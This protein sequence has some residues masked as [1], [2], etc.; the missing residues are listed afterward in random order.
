MPPASVRTLAH[1]RRA[2][3]LARDWATADRLKSEIEEAGWRVVDRGPDFALVPAIPA[4][5][6][7][8]GVLVHGAPER[9][10]SELAAP[11]SPGWT[12]VLIGAG[13][14]PVV[15]G[16][17]IVR[18]A[19]GSGPVPVDDAETLRLPAG[20]SPAA[21]IEAGLRRVRTEW[22]VLVPDLAGAPAPGRLLTALS[23]DAV[24]GD[25][26]VVAFGLAGATTAD[27]H[28]F[29]PVGAGDADVLLAGPL[30]VRREDLAAVLP[31][32][33]R[34][35]SPDRF[36]EW[37]SLALRRD[38]TPADDGSVRRT[39]VVDAGDA[40]G[41]AR[42]AA[43]ATDDRT[44]KRDFYRILDRFGLDPSLLSIDR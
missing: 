35:V 42:R 22:V 37:L 2:A 40:D 34:I 3:R 36:F 8:D 17:P 5:V 30:A 25:R 1:D 15:D 23:Q 43:E 41:I 28:A 32:D 16:V 7:I 18:V 39:V 44:A 38:A 14:A 29:E 12:L 11:A 19:A 20:S 13:P 6:T 10:P 21:L 4:D 33:R 31:F 26:A 9:V 27:L 24:V